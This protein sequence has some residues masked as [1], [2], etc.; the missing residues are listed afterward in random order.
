MLFV[1]ISITTSL[2]GQ[3][4]LSD[5]NQKINAGNNESELYLKRAE[6]YDQKNEFD[7]SN[8]DYKKVIDN[9]VS[10]ADKNKDAA[11]KAYYKLADDYMYRKSSTDNVLQYVIGGLDI[12]PEHKGL[13]LIKA[14][15]LY[16]IGQ[17][18]KSFEIYDTLLSKD[19]EDKKVLTEYA[20]KLEHRNPEKAKDIY[21][22]IVD[23]N[24]ENSDAL[25]FLAMYYSELANEM[26]LEGKSPKE[27]IATMKQATD[28]LS[29][30]YELNPEDEDIKETL[31]M[32]YRNIGESK[33]AD[34]LEN[35][36]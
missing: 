24:P 22:I 27:V 33:K 19:Q 11:V 30:Y 29:K 7:K 31:I 13:L 35:N 20:T 9:Y 10:G 36:E 8:A 5:L 14:E 18:E 2:S 3:N 6:I 16:R 4:N 34:N 28:Y 1:A 25:Y 26:N 21:E 15:A 12:D 23:K 17:N 32:F